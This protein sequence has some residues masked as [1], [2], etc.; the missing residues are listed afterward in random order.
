[1][2]HENKFREKR[3]HA[4]PVR[5]NH[6]YDEN[7]RILSR[8]ISKL[9]GLLSQIFIV[10]LIISFISYLFVYHND[11]IIVESHFKNFSFDSGDKIKNLG[12]LWGAMMSYVFIY[13]YFGFISS[14][15]ILFLFFIIGAKFARLKFLAK[16]N[17]WEIIYRSI[18]LI[19]IINS[20]IGIFHL[21]N[22]FNGN[23]S[24]FLS[25]VIASFMFKYFGIGTYFV[26]ALCVMIFALPFVKR[27]FKKKNIEVENNI[28]VMSEEKV[29][30]VGEK[31]V[32][33]D[34]EVEN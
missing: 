2:T 5:R 14:L 20:S 32:G 15:I 23:F 1:M 16:W 18:F 19:F 27:C 21:G 26:F 12:G 31:V 30:N 25:D 9:I 28:E 4:R 22:L 33:D 34:K 7:E 11:Q 17:I 10:F 24:G 13:K 8:M 3:D 6:F 29:E